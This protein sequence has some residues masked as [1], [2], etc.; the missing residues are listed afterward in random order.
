VSRFSE[1]RGWIKIPTTCVWCGDPFHYYSSL[2]NDEPKRVV[3]YCSR[4]C[5]AEARWDGRS[6]LPPVATLRRLY[7][8]EQWSQPQIG[9]QYGV[10]HK[11]VRNALLKAGIILRKGTGTRNCV[12]C[13]APVWKI[14]VRRNGKLVLTGKRCKKHQH[15]L[16][17]I[18]Q[19]KYSR[20]RDPLIGSRKLGSK[21]IPCCCSK[22]FKPHPSTREAVRCCSVDWRDARPISL[23]CGAAR[24]LLTA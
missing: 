2:V 8:V 14:P 24:L 11:S 16:W 9:K 5:V 10:S 3:L 21:Y 4:K 12:V 15:E 13:G 7:V 19:H 20:K 23:E 18:T 17:R 22:C 6:K 1:R